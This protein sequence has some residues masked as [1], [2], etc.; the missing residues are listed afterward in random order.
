ML[1]IYSEA[2]TLEKSN[3]LLAAGEELARKRQE[4]LNLDTKL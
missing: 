4:R 2:T 3:A 1:R